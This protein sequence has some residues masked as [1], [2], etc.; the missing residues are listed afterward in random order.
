MNRPIP[1]LDLMWLLLEKPQCPLHV[2]GVFVFEKRGHRGDVVRE[3]VEAYRAA[4]PTPPYNFVPVLRSGSLPQF[5]ETSGFDPD[6]HIQHIALPE[7]AGDVDLLRLIASLHETPLDRARPLFRTWVIDGLPGNRFALYSKVHHSITDGISGMQRMYASLQTRPLRAVPTPA[8]GVEA[9][10]RKPRPPEPWP[11]RFK[12]L[13]TSAAR[14]ATAVR[15]VSAGVLGKMLAALAGEAQGSVPFMARRAPM[16]EPLQQ[17]RSLT[18]LSLS[19]DDMHRLARR[20][21]ATLNDVAVTIVDA[22]IH[23]YLRE[24]ERPFGHRLVAM[25]PVSLRDAGDGAA[26]TKASAMFVRLGEHHADVGKRFQ[27]VT[28]SLR[29]G[30]AELRAMS[31]DAALT[32]AVSILAMAETA[33]VAH[34]SQLAPPLANVV[35]SNVPGL[36]RRLYLNGAPLVGVY[37]LSALAASIGLN[38]T[39]TS[40][41]DRMAFGFVGNGAVMSDLARLSRHVEAA[42]QELGTAAGLGTVTDRS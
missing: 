34:V 7:G 8:F 4:R 6:Y 11:A 24:S 17:A 21:G 32:Y 38:V 33:A 20:H 29:I 23:R 16:N 15:A 3:I 39:F 37:P 27:Q 1:P 25:C 19:L 41:H 9:P 31:K 12:T 26:G 40:Y 35:I 42:Y 13:G 22:G 14:Q 18:T 30:K 10:H 28:E 5:R 36:R 2:G